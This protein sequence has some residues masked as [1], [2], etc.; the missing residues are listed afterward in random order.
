MGAK[1][2]DENTEDAINIMADYTGVDANVA[3]ASVNC[4]DRD[5]KI[6]DDKIAA[7]KATVEFLIS[8]N[9]FDTSSDDC[10]IKSADDITKY[11]NTSYYD[12]IK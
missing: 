11:I 1:Y 10:V 9:Q 6:T 3:S 2:T 7:F 12:A 5:V 4:E 8:S